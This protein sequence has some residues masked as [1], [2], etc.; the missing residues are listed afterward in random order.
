MN[1][2]QQK[3]IVGLEKVQTLLLLIQ[4]QFNVISINIIFLSEYNTTKA[5]G[6]DFCY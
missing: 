6:N 2:L 1:L 4:K 3:I 5:A